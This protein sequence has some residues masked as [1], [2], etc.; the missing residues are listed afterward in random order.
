MR[1]WRS[2]LLCALLAST[3]AVAQ[4]TA[5]PGEPKKCALEGNVVTAS[6]EPIKK[7]LVEIIGES[8][9][10]GANYSAVA[11]QDGHFRV[12][13]LQPG[14]YRIFVERTGFIQVD[15]KN[16]RGPGIV[17]SLEAGQEV[18]D[19]L[20]RMLPTAAIT[21]RVVDEDGDPIP[22]VDVNVSRKTYVAGRQNW[23]IIGS[24]RTNDI[25]Q[26]RV[27][28]L[29]PGRYFIAAVPPASFQSIAATPKKADPANPQPE[30]AYV[31][32]YYPGTID[33]SQA[34]PVEVHAGDELPVDFALI[35]S[36]TFRIR[37]ELTALPHG[38]DA[39]VTLQPHD[40]GFVVTAGAEV[41]KDGSFELRDVP[42]GSYTVYAF[43]QSGETTLTA[44]RQVEV[45]DS[46]VEGVQLSATPGATI[47]GR[48]HVE[49]NRVPNFKS[50]FVSLGDDSE[51]MN[52]VPIKNG[53]DT[54]GRVKE[55]GSFEIQNIPSGLFRVQLTTENPDYF[56]KSIAVDG[57][58]APGSRLTV[59]GGRFAVDLFVSGAA[60]KVEGT[61][62]N[63]KGEPVPNAVV[64][65][66]PEPKFRK[67]ADHY[68][69]SLADQHGRFTL[70][71]LIPGNYTVFA[72]ED[73]DGEPYFDP[74]FLKARESEGLN[75][76]IDEGGHVK[77][78]LKAGTSDAAP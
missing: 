28:G 67:E 77:V 45:T 76:R 4:S 17:L 10:R 58:T 1:V 25:G 38:A 51:S 48:I 62:A 65:A 22:S 42:P 26:F 41:H 21:G 39:G 19:L 31:T 59:N 5:N 50:F 20:L 2:A 30:T 49:G 72:W 34:T 71:G 60:G 70:R 56:L 11:D 68:Q 37:G 46:D 40:P 8:S 33:R 12:G 23:E 78:A 47:Q 52:M 13:A 55:D 54:I 6:G 14:R 61:V 53:L 64:V 69:H 3:L 18:R 16:H 73:L 75:L 9:E 35:P 63:D 7:A 32:A 43:V 15:R 29:L 24:E 57:T 27:G 36:R 66:V 44:H 74:D